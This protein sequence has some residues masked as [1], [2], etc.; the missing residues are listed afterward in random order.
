[1]IIILVCLVIAV[2]SYLTGYLYGFHK[3][4][5]ITEDEYLV[6]LE[7]AINKYLHSKGK[8]FSETVFEELKEILRSKK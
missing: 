7:R 4:R 6:A 1:M 3:N 5:L 2:L 8:T